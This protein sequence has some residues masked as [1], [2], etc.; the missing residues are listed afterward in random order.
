MRIGIDI[1]EIRPQRVT[2]TGRLLSTFLSHLG[3]EKKKEVFLFAD[4][5]TDVSSF[6]EDFNVVVNRAP[7]SF[8]YDQV[9]IARLV[10]QHA[11]DVLFLPFYKACFLAGS[12]QVICVN[13]LYFLSSMLRTGL[14][15]IKPYINY[16]RHS[17]KK[18]NKIITISRYSRQEILKMF[19]PEENK[20]KVVYPGIAE[21]FRKLDNPSREAFEQKYGIH[22]LY[23]LYVG[24]LSPHKNISALLKAYCMLPRELQNLYKLVIVAQKD[25]YFPKAEEL[26]NRLGIKERVV[27]FDF[28]SDE[29]LVWFYNFAHI[30]VF[31]SF[32]EGFGLPPIEAMA[33]GAAVIA[34]NASC[35]SE[36]LGEGAL[37][38]D[39]KDQGSLAIQISRLAGSSRLR[40]D[41]L[42][43]GKLQAEKYS[44]GVF[45]SNLLS[46][47]E[48]A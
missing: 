24:N 15:C 22:S 30:F 6:K 2:G 18:A 44:A 3:A 1:R 21:I 11:I 47:I 16:V 42:A 41:L 20:V 46:E 33:C 9:T 39:P 5:F 45:A 28:I 35:L 4:S 32:Y 13:D 19:H 31:P 10:K 25:G 7:F 23:I 27:M 37:Y 12:K 34:S 43:K 40:E 17:I 14:R 29:E 26:I 8:W 38:V 36:T 48:S